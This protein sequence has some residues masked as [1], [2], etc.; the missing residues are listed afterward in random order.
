MFEKNFTVT[1]KRISRTQNWSN[2][3]KCKEISNMLAVTKYR[4][5]R[6]HLYYMK[7]NYKNPPNQA[8]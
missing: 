2:I 7:N 6:D 5:G 1:K 8:S 4:Q 3:Q